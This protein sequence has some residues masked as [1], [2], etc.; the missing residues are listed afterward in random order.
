[1]T[2]YLKNEGVEWCGRQR[3]T[4]G[5]YRWKLKWTGEDRPG[6]VGAP[7]LTKWQIYLQAAA[8]DLEQLGRVEA[9]GF[10]IPEGTDIVPTK[11]AA[12]P[13]EGFDRLALYFETPDDARA[14][15]AALRELDLLPEDDRHEQIDRIRGITHRALQLLTGVILVIALLGACN[16]YVIQAQLAPPS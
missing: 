9:K 16:L 15:I 14:V 12:P 1:V 4:D 2:A 8:N 5:T 3:L 13:P 11:P 10:D 7:P 6:Q